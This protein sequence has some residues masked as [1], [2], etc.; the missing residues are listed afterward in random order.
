[1]YYGVATFKG[2][3]LFDYNPGKDDSLPDL[4][5]Y[6]LRFIDWVHAVLSG[7][8]FAVVALRDRN[9]VSC[10]YPDPSRE[11]KEVLDIVPIGVGLVCSLLFIA[12]P[13]KRHGIG[14]P[15]TAGK[16]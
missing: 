16:R 7:L 9:V 13:T 14:Y 15:V 8:V 10:L 1:M 5:N 11:V 6:K 3:W 2:M 4:R 12:F